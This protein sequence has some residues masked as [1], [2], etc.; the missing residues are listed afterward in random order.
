[1]LSIPRLALADA[2]TLIAGA[3]K[4]ARRIRV[5]MCIAVT[6][7]SGNLIAFERM[8][9]AKVLSVQLSQDKA[10]TAAISRRPTHDYNA[11]AVPGNLVFGI[12]SAHGGRFSTVGG[13]VPVEVAGATVGGIGCSSGTPEQD[14]ACAEAGV[15]AFLK[16]LKKT[17]EKAG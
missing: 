15:R 13:G 11:R 6:D 14:R 1:M 17:R 9:G 16:S 5:P 3:R 8:D 10:F 2:Q 4:E 12:Q 7:E